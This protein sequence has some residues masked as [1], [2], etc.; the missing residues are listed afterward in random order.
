MRILR[1]IKLA[2]QSKGRGGSSFPSAGEKFFRPGKIGIESAENT[3]NMRKRGDGYVGASDS[4]YKHRATGGRDSPSP[5]IT[6]REKVK[7]YGK[8]KTL[9]SKGGRAGQPP[10]TAGRAP[11]KRTA[12]PQ[13]RNG[14]P[15]QTGTEDF[16]W[17]KGYGR[18]GGGVFVWTSPCPGGEGQFNQRG[19]LG[20][21]N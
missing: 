4:F 18:T 1:G 5:M 3:R 14:A 17:Q 12:A 2:D 6:A 20:G 8:S 21:E 13:R 9:L 16:P 7:G 11:N 10:A 19:R 15:S